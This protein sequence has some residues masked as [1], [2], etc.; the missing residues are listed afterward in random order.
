M[1]GDHV[2]LL[3]ILEC[4]RRVETYSARDQDL[5]MSSEMVQDATL[6]NLQILS[7]STQRLSEAAKQSYPEVEW[8]AIAGFRN[9]LTHGYLG[10]DL[11]Q[12]W[13]II[14]R[15]VPELKRAVSA[16]LGETDTA[17]QPGRVVRGPGWTGE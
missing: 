7:E 13:R 16:L 15:D 9:V 3:H 17:S 2:Y 6:R 5:F 4:V 10:I 12:I 8:K 14:Q 1:K 11:E